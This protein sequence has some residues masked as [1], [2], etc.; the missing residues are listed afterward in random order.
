MPVD[1]FVLTDALAAK[2]NVNWF[3]RKVCVTWITK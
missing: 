2:K 1:S 3:L